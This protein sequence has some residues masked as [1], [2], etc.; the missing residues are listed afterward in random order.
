MVKSFITLSYGGQ[1]KYCRNLLQ[2]FK[3]RKCRNCSKLLAQYFIT[4]AFGANVIKPFLARN[5]R[6]FILS[7]NVCYT[8]L[9]KLAT[10]KHSSLLRKVVHYGQKSFIA[11]GPGHSFY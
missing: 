7:S 6:I 5:L 4:L 8:R 11:L 2:I 9:E 1:L 3:S 10:D